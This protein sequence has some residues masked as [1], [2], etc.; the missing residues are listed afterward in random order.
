MV[1]A[2]EKVAREPEA[3]AR[4]AA[5][6]ARSVAQRARGAVAEVLPAREVAMTEAREARLGRAV[7]AEERWDIHTSISQ[8][9]L[10][11][12]LSPVS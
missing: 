1:R 4:A 5:A 11:Y 2:T 12:S 8:D 9:R 3:G 7:F 10:M 6:R